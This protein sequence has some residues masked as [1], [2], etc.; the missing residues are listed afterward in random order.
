VVAPFQDDERTVFKAHAARC[1]G[2]NEEGC[3]GQCPLL[4]KWTARAYNDRRFVR[5][6]ATKD[7][8]SSSEGVAISAKMRASEMKVVLVATF[9]LAE[10]S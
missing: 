1:S 7:A 2:V 9:H 5:A 8:P 4:A 3:V 6:D 10:E